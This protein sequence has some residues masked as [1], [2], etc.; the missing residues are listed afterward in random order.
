MQTGGRA[1]KART[2]LN[3]YRQDMV[4]LYAQGNSYASI[5]VWLMETH[6]FEVGLGVLYRQMKRWGAGGNVGSQ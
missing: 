1:T 2:N 3:P 4:E 6:G 5:R